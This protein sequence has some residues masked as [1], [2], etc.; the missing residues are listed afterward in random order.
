[1]LND[2]SSVRPKGARSFNE[3]VADA[4]NMALDVTY[5][6]QPDIAMFREIT[7]FITRNGLTVAIPFPRFMFNSMELMGNYAGG[8]SIPL[9][10]KLFGQIPKG[11]RLSDKDRQRISRN[12]VGI[13][14]MGA[15]WM[16]RSQE[17]APSDYKELNMGDGTVMDTTPQF[18]SSNAVFR[19]GNKASKG[20]H[21]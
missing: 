18:P 16:A 13:A 10:K 3:L 6:K 5:A 19:R 2:A 12:F 20:W 17:D 15:A 8:A 1:M 4:T 9:T 11:T 7:S 21:I 14:A